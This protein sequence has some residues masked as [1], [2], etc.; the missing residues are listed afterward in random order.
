M[1][2][3]IRALLLGGVALAVSAASSSGLTGQIVGNSVRI[4][5]ATLTTCEPHTWRFSQ[6]DAPFVSVHFSKFRVS[7]SDIV[8]IAT[9][10]NATSKRV[11]VPA[12]TT[13]FSSDRIPGPTAV[14][15]FTPVGC[16]AQEDAK[17]PSDFGLQI[18]AFE[19]T[20]AESYSS[21]GEDRE[22]CGTG[23]QNKAAVCFKHATNVSSQVYANAR[24]I[25]RLLISSGSDGP[26]VACTGFLLGSNG[27]LVTNHHCIKD[28]DQANRT[29]FEFMVE[30]PTC[31]T[32]SCRQLGDCAQYGKVESYGAEFLYANEKYDY[33]VVKLRKKP[34][35]VN[36]KYGFLKLRKA[37]PVEG[38]PIYI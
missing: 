5:N 22:I 24:A 6:P 30:S 20:L 8:T 7:D 14:V 4:T 27:H 38:E 2:V 17:L 3:R 16:L 35:V 37:K 34:C 25:A 28:A 31:D 9:L 10:D 11:E 23:D 26:Q 18:S 19:Y 32:T 12:G 33:A 13:S 21:V 15:T 36:G 1:G 29:N